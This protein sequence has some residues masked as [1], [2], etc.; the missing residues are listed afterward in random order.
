MT[1]IDWNRQSKQMQMFLFFLW[2][3]DV[4]KKGKNYAFSLLSLKWES[5]NNNI[6]FKL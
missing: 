4:G 2:S 1:K 6:I 3:W 5:W